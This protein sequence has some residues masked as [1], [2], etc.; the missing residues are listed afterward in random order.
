M[1]CQRLNLIKVR[2]FIDKY[3]QRKGELKTKEQKISKYYQNNIINEITL[4]QKC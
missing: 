2:F 3:C 4:K 1:Y